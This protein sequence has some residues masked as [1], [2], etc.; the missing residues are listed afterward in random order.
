MRLAVVAATGQVG[1]DLERT[2]LYD[3]V[4]CVVVGLEE[5]KRLIRA[6]ASGA[7]A[8]FAKTRP[9]RLSWAFGE[10]LGAEENHALVKMREIRA[11]RV[12]RTM[13]RYGL[14][15]DEARERYRET[16]PAIYRGEYDM[17]E[18]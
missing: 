9:A 15:E 7:S 1:S 14:T 2:T 13:R 3:A 5:E 4:A 11:G 16:V 6:V 12:R 17:P 18:A 10:A 8:L